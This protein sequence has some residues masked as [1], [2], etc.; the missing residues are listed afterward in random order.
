MEV[1]KLDAVVRREE[2]MFLAWKLLSV[3]ICLEG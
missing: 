2:L 1:L 3:Q